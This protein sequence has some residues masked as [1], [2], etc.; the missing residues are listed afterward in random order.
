[1][2]DAISPTV[3]V[4]VP[5]QAGL[6]FEVAWTGYDGGVGIEWFDVE[7]KQDGQA[8]TGWLTNTLDTEAM[9][10]AESGQ[11]YTFRVRATDRVGNV[12]QDEASVDVY[13]AVKYYAFNGQRVAMRRCGG[14]ECGE[15]VY[16]HGDHPSL[17]SGQALGSVSLA[18][19]E[20]GN[21]LAQARYAPYGQ[22]RWNG[23]TAMP[24][25]FAFTGQRQ[26]GFGLMDYNARFYSPRMGRFVSADSL[27]PNS[28]DPAYYD[29]YSYVRN[30]PIRRVDISGHLDCDAPHVAPGDCAAGPTPIASLQLNL[31]SGLQQVVRNAQYMKVDYI[32]HPNLCGQIA[33]AM[34]AEIILGIPV[35]IKDIARRD[36]IDPGELTDSGDLVRI[37][38]NLI[39]ESTFIV[40]AGRN[41]TMYYTD[42]SIAQIIKP[43]SEAGW[44]T[45]EN[46]IGFMAN[47]IN[48]GNQLIL[49]IYLDQSPG[50][51]GLGT[52]VGSDLDGIGNIVVGHWVAVSAVYEGFIEI[53]DPYCNCVRRVQNSVIEEAM[54]NYGR[55]IVVVPP[56][57]SSPP[58]S[59]KYYQYQ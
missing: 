41:K 54:N 19:D 3:H 57:P 18:T 2:E 6:L 51:S 22:V 28:F 42:G 12:G 47:E 8:W 21:L 46:V 13:S 25:K 10:V 32:P 40:Y 59:T 39:P 7:Y 35:N 15:A 9:F 11:G 48:Y 17:C 23:E 34:I 16:L 30:N 27:M 26:D 14:S 56:Y 29:R 31:A 1:M 55:V 49:G 50:V 24:T 36:G 53:N 58:P 37:G 44:V 45:S 33:L 5:E 52:I 43:A 38:R 4:L 20:Q